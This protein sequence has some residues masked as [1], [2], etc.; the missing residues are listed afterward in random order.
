VGGFSYAIPAQ[1]CYQNTPIDP[2]YQ[3]SYKVG[4][5]TWSSGTA[6]L[7][8]NGNSFAVDDTIS[9]AGVIPSGYNGTWQVKA[10]TPSSVSFFLPSNPGPYA[11]GGTLSSPNVLLFNAAHCYAYFQSNPLKINP[12]RNLVVTR[13]H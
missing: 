9:V 3:N 13:V 11:S 12:P 6:T 7:A 4:A 1:L 2:S 10:V 5:A 8:T